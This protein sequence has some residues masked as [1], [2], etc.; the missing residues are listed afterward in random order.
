MENEKYH[1]NVLISG[2]LKLYSYLQKEITKL[3]QMVDTQK[4][5]LT[6]KMKKAALEFKQKL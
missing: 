5:S 4:Q 1:Q 2:G 6:A 3:R